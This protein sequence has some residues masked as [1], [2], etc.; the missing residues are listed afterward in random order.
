MIC[1]AV[2]K[3]NEKRC[4]LCDKPRGH[5]QNRDEWHTKLSAI[6]GLTVYLFEVCAACKQTATIKECLSK[7]TDHVLKGNKGGVKKKNE[8]GKYFLRH[9]QKTTSRRA[10]RI[11][12]IAEAMGILR[13]IL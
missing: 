4:L 3:I 2:V 5:T 10:V 6:Y 13:T 8:V 12:P 7:V 11:P 9:I 1:L